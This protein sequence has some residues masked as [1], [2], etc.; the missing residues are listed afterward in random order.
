MVFPGLFLFV[1]V[2]STVKSKYV[3][4]KIV[5]MT[6]FEL[7]A[8]GIRSNH[9]ATAPYETS[10]KKG[11]GNPS[12]SVVTLSLLFYPSTFILKIQQTLQGKQYK[13]FVMISARQKV[14]TSYCYCIFADHKGR[15]IYIHRHIT[16]QVGGI[17]RLLPSLLHCS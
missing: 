1:F 15:Y 3:H 5:L 6:R 16:G 14:C 8:S 7:W 12:A 11:L 17:N 4:Y 10:F 2:L 9:S 13:Q